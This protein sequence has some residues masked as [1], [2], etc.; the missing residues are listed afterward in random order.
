MCVPAAKDKT[1]EG[2]SESI[3]SYLLAAASVINPL[4]YRLFYAAVFS[5][6]LL[7]PLLH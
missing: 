2:A 5:V 7:L 6:F 4:T 3:K 1:V